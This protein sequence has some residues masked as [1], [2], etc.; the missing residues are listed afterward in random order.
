MFM[1]KT[2]CV[3]VLLL[4]TFALT[5][6]DKSAPAG[7]FTSPQIVAKGKLR[8]QTAPIPATAIF[9]PPQDGVYRLNIY[10]TITTSDSNSQSAW[11]VNVGWT[12]DTSSTQV[13]NTVLEGNGY[14]P[15][16]FVHPNPDGS[17]WFALG[18]FGTPVEAKA[19]TPITYTVQQFGPADGSVYSIYY[20]LERLE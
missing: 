20:T 14:I 17:S 15:G 13:A 4:P 2:L 1:Y 10:A 9:T 5:Q 18:G 7:A 3:A 8:N 19:G 16:Q 11:D 6:G 12:D